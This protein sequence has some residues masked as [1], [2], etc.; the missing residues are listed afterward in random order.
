[1]SYKPDIAIIGPGVVGTTLGVLAARAGYP[2][3]GVAGRSEASAR[4]AVERMGVDA[5]TGPA[6]EVAAAG[7]LVL[8]TV[9]DN[10]IASLCERLAKAGAFA[11]GAIVA[12]CCGAM[13]GEIL[14]PARDCGAAIGSMHPLQTFP[15]VEAGLAKFAGT[16]CFCEGDDD[17]VAALAALAEAI[18]GKPVRISSQG[19]LLYHAAAVMAC[20]YLIALLD[21][22]LAT[23]EHADIPREQARDALEPLIRATL[24]NVLAQG[25][26]EAL[27]GPIARGDDQLIARQLADVEAADTKLGD[28]YRALGQWTIDLA[29]R[30][31]TIDEAKAELLRKALK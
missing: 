22:A 13:P 3:A 25:P 27:T 18:G 30:K 6:E 24:D 16:Y 10:A 31:G 19:K 4:A 15:D 21:A 9:D 7:K 1:M 23:A 26:A 20:N 11:D 12:H 8:L 14:A 28:I 17:A 2:I 29:L 5:P